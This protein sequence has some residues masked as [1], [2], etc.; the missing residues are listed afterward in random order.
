MTPEALR[1]QFDVLAEAPNGVEKL[2]ELVLRLAFQGRLLGEPST[3]VSD[4]LPNGWAWRTVGDLANAIDSGFACNKQNEVADGYVHLRTHNVGTDGR[5]NFDLVVR[6]APDR[7]HPERAR[8]QAGDVLFNNTN[9][10]ELVGKTC[11]VDRDYEY[12]FS[13]HLTRVRVSD[14]VAP[15][16]LVRYFNLL[17]RTGYFASY[18]N[19]WIGQAGINSKMLREVTIPVAPIAEQRRI[20]AKVDEL[21]AL[22]DELEAQQQRRAEARVRANRSVLHHLVEASGDE[23]LAAGWERLRENFGV[24]YDA[25]EPLAELRQSVLQLAVRGKLVPF[26]AASCT[27]PLGEVLAESS[28]NGIATKPHDGPTGTPIL[29]IS[30]GTARRDGIVEESDHKFLDLDAASIDTYALRPGDLLAC[31]FNGNLRFVGRMSL[32]T[33]ASGATQVY[34]DK[35]IRYRVAPDRADPAYVRHVFNAPDTRRLIEAE[36]ATTAGNIGISAER[37][38]TIPIPVPSLIEQRRTIARIDAIMALCD[39]LDAQLTHARERSARLADSVV[40]RLTAA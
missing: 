28:L 10:Q 7:V 26:D 37:L 33:G 23:A 30:A 21:M 2:R 14:A 29:R 22:C 35:L 31:R 1:A 18:C 6:I 8:L 25:P 9:S 11:L 36:C 24:L 38:R 20:L 16:Y 39:R 40:H 27:A 12:G 13:N 3:R 32:Y 15:G 17:L 4:G 34:P 5:L 19:R